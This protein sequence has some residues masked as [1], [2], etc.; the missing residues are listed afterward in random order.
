MTTAPPL[1]DVRALPSVLGLREA[2]RLIGV[3]EATIYTMAANN[4]LPFPAFR[5][6]RQ[7][8]VP[9]AGV[10]ALLGIEA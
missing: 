1:A 3:G 2:G 4:D 6:G 10:L 5:V 9:T 7:W 8:R